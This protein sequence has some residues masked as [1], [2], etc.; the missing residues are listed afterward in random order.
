MVN[1][2]L[3]LDVRLSRLP[4]SGPQRAHITHWLFTGSGKVERVRDLPQPFRGWVRNPDRLRTINADS[5]R[6]AR[7]NRKTERWL[8]T[9]DV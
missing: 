5:E 8:R 7:V 1:L 2:S 9:L 4:V 6:A 3:D